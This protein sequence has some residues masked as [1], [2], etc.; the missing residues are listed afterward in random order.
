MDEIPWHE[1]ENN[2]NINLSRINVL[3]LT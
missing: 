3:I 1:N 2:E